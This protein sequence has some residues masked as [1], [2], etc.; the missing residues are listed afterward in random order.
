ML[1]S[2]TSRLYAG[3]AGLK[4]NNPTQAALEQGYI[5][6]D[7]FYADSH[8]PLRWRGRELYAPDL[9]IGRLVETPARDHR[10]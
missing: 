9:A 4:P 8:D 10:S 2:R 1:S 5:L 7:D 3:L 6:T